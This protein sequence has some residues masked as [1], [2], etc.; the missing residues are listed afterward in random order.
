MVG[1]YIIL[2][3]LAVVGEVTTKASILVRGQWF[4]ET[5]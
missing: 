5:R 1:T 2:V 4:F 3:V